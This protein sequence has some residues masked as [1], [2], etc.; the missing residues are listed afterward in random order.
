MMFSISRGEASFEPLDE[1]GCSPQHN[2]SYLSRPTL[3]S[4][5]LT[6]IYESATGHEAG[7]VTE[8]VSTHY[9]GVGARTCSGGGWNDHGALMR[10]GRQLE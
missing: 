6:F 1:V 8:V 10:S 4:V 3:V 5:L 2:I 7:V 9:A